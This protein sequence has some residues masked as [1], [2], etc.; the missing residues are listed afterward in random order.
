MH[1]SQFHRYSPYRPAA[2]RQER[3]LDL[4][5]HL[6]EPKKPHRRRDD[7]YVREYYRF[8]L[9]YMAQTTEEGRA[10]LFEKNPALFYAHSLHFHP[11]REWRSI[12]QGFLLTGDPLPN[13]ADAVATLPETLDWYEKLFFN[14]RDRLHSEV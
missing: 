9:K 6:P 14:V 5:E 8:L 7:K 10:N 13:C 1:H 2:W 11:D 12:A 3:V 4:A